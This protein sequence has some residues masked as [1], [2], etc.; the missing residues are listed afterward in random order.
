MS[1]LAKWSTVAPTRSP[2]AG[3]LGRAVVSKA[4]QGVKLQAVVAGVGSAVVM[5]TL[6]NTV[7]YAVRAGG[8][9]EKAGCRRG[10]RRRVHVAHWRGSL[11][12]WPFSRIH[13][14]EHCAPRGTT[15]AG[16]PRPAGVPA[17]LR[18]R[19]RCAA[20]PAGP[21]GVLSWGARPASGRP[22]RSTRCGGPLP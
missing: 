17:E 7:G 8:A 2:F 14:R 20:L 1:A 11:M 15:V 22:A 9:Q 5:A 6:K 12:V 19:A 16:S 10:I 4:G 13:A 3:V 18:G 21:W